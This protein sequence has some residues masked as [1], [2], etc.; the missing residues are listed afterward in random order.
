MR[1]PYPL[2]PKTLTRLLPLGAPLVFSVA[3][4]TKFDSVRLARVVLALHIFGLFPGFCEHRTFVPAAGEDEMGGLLVASCAKLRGLG[5]L[6]TAIMAAFA[7]E[8]AA[9][10]FAEACASAKGAGRETG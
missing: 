9:A 5:A 7:D 8:L 6:R 4:L 10:A 2:P 3:S 1:Q